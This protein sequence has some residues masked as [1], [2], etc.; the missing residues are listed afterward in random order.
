MKAVQQAV[1][2]IYR[3]REE[4]SDAVGSELSPKLLSEIMGNIDVIV[5]GDPSLTEDELLEG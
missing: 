3:S 5:A 4:V 2:A 1:N